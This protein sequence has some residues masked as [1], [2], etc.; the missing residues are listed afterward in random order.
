MFHFPNIDSALNNQNLNSLTHNIVFKSSF[1]IRIA[2]ILF[3]I[4]LLSHSPA[5]GAEIDNQNSLNKALIDS[6]DSIHITQLS[7]LEVIARKNKYSKKDNPAYELMRKIRDAKDRTDPKTL[8]SYAEDNYTKITIGLK[9]QDAERYLKNQKLRFL[10]EYMDTNVHTGEEVL[11]LSVREKATVSLHDGVSNKNEVLLKNERRVGIDDNLAPDN[12]TKVMEDFLKNIDIFK[13]D[14]VLMQQR[15]VSPLSHLADNFYHYSLNDTVYIN[16]KPHIELVFSPARGEMFGFNGRLYMEVGDSTYFVKRVEMKVPRYIN[17]NYVD[18]LYATLDYVKDEYGKRHIEKDDL[19]LEL[20]VF[21]SSPTL[22]LRRLSINDTPKFNLEDE[23]LK[24]LDEIREHLVY[25]N[26]SEEPWNRWEEIRLSPLSPAENEMGSMMGR[27]R[28]FPLIYWTEKI[29]K[30]LV[31]G[32]IA[33]SPNS[34]VD[35]GPVNTF[36]SY[37]SIEGMRFRVGGITTANL[38]DHWFGRGYIA[39]GSRDKKFKYNAELEYSFNKKKYHSREFPVN[40]FRIHYNYEL[41]N[42]GQHYYFTNPD[43]V[44]LSLKRHSGRLSLYRREVGITYQIEF[45]NNFS[46]T[47]EFRHRIYESTPWLPFIDGNGKALSRYTLA[48]FRLDLRYA[49]GEE[50]IQSGGARYPINFDAPIFRLSHEFIPKG[51]L[52]SQ[53]CLNK[54]EISFSKRFWFSA[55]GYLDTLLKGGILWS[56]VNYPSLLWQN[57]NLSYTIQPESYSLMNPMEFA[58]DHFGSIDLSYFANGLI[59]NNIPILKKL[60]LR[61]VITFKGLIGGLTR[62]NN[63]EYNLNLFR[64]PEDAEVH[65]LSK[66][67]YMELGVGLDNILTCLR[68]D[69]IWRLTYRHVQ[70]APDSGL[71]VSLHFSF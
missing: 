60:K 56:Q 24:I 15:F 9:G 53:F 5:V 64:F 13:D 69:Y 1:L 44:F 25:A 27:L 11:L 19:S 14:V 39:Y 16:G 10:K 23:T 41:D 70:G 22:Y 33:T 54:T 37:N 62:K 71:R 30:V 8:P 12:I 59:F 4:C 48:G 67:P 50:F 51:F 18:N 52:G 17:L 55:F 68:V 3:F 29:L 21:P 7:E 45:H 34:K 57:A 58:F 63:P 35:I 20:S 40:S 32:Y 38:S 65:L 31:N 47:G 36:L 26:P 28:K 42:I 66:K 49:P 43:N 46:I 61:E 2:S 6:S